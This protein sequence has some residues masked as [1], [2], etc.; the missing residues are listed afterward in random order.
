MNNI[1]KTCGKDAEDHK[2]ADCGAESKEHDEM[3]ACGGDRC[4]PKCVEGS[5]AEENCTLPWVD[6]LS[7]AETE[8]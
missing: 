1:C 2:C 6:H 7:E 5:E 8:M 3:H 4:Q